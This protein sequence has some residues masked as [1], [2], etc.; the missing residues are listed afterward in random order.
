MLGGN[1][2]R[3]LLQAGQDP[4]CLARIRVHNPGETARDV[5]AVEHREDERVRAEGGRAD[6]EEHRDKVLFGVLRPV[7]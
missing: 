6:G 3:R 1:V 5:C 2:Q 7:R 4:Y